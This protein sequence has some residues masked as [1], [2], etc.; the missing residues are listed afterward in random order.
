[1]TLLLRLSLVQELAST[2][3][4][5]PGEPSL[6]M[7]AIILV[8]VKLGGTV[9]VTPDGKDTGAALNSGFDPSFPDTVTWSCSGFTMK[10]PPTRFSE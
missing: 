4:G 10:L 5:V 9:S 3:K 2:V 8:H 7:V 6:L 1:M